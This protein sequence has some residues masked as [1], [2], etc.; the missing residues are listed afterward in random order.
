LNIPLLPGTHTWSDVGA[1]DP[2]PNRI[3]IAAGQVVTVTL[4]TN[5]GCGDSCP[6][7]ATPDP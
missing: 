7:A 1:D 5:Y 2:K 6:A 3:V 4:Q